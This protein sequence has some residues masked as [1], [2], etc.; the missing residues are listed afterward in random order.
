MFAMYVERVLIPD[1][2]KVSGA[3]ER[4]AAAVGCV[5]LL[6]E[7]AHFRQGPLAHLWPGL[8]QVIVK[9]FVKIVDSSRK[10]KSF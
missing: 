4:K 9:T 5:K 7:S 3:L 8:L 6:C 10:P 1:L 2:Q